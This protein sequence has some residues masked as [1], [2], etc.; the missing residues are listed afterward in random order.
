M[1]RK[2]SLVASFTLI[3]VGVVLMTAVSACASNTFTVLHNFDNTGYDPLGNLIF[4]STGHIYG[5]AAL[6]GLANPNCSYNCGVVFELSSSGG[7]WT[8]KTIYSFTGG[9][10]GLEP[11]SRL[12]LDSKGNLYGTAEGGGTVDGNYCPYGC[13]T[14][15][16]LS[17]SG[18]VWTFTLLHSFN[19]LDGSTPRT[20]LTLDNAGNLYGTT[21]VGGSGGAGTIFELSPS[22]NGWTFSTLYNLANSG[23][24]GEFPFSDLVIDAAGNLYGA[25]QQGGSSKSSCSNYCGTVFELSPSGS[26]WKFKLLHAFLGAKYGDGGLPWG[27]LSL[28]SAGNLY[29][30][31]F[32]GGKACDC[33]TVFKLSQSAGIWKKQIL[34][35]FS[36]PDGQNPLGGVTMGKAGNLYGTTLDGGSSCGNCG[37]V[38]RLTLGLNGYWKF[39]SLHSFTFGTDGAEPYAGV[40]VDALGN[41]YGTT[42]GGGFSFE[43]T[44]FE[45]SLH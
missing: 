5:T 7:S 28:D 45:L 1:R 9:A 19:G 8:Y 30:T 15:F 31:T 13:G 21:Q 23:T 44:L 37:T 26:S 33:G 41:L 11:A 22:G 6:G 14:V 36:G 25:T 27:P 42:T 43:G 20:G 10:D 40:I 18:S 34:H 29:G 32:E 39:T 12:T 2:H 17:P 38:F 16:E 4:D 35:R 24:E 3:A